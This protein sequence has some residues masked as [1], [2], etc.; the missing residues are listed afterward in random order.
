MRI[1]HAHLVAISFTVPQR[2]E[3]CIFIRWQSQWA[4]GLLVMSQSLPGI[5]IIHHVSRRVFDVVHLR[6]RWQP[7]PNPIRWDGGNVWQN[8]SKSDPRWQQL[9]GSDILHT[10]LELQNW[11][12]GGGSCHTQDLK[13]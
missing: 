7:V 5:I 10:T 12:W 4:A 6:H 2:T 13:I 1:T 11:D 8:L 9:R 3:N